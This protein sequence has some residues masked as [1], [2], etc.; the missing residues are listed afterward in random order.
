MNSGQRV[1]SKMSIN[2]IEEKLESQMIPPDLR[3]DIEHWITRHE[4]GEDWPDTEAIKIHG[5]LALYQVRSGGGWDDPATKKQ[6]NLISAMSNNKSVP[7]SILDEIDL[8]ESA[9]G[10]QATKGV[11]CAWIECLRYYS[12]HNKG[13]KRC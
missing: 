4:R 7:E 12:A 2:V 8:I 9:P 13:R 6:I 3:L 10:S 1:A 11:A 5:Q